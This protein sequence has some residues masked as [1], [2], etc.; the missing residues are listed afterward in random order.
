MSWLTQQYSTAPNP[1]IQ[2][3]R[4]HDVSQIG[5]TSRFICYKLND[6]VLV[7]GT[8]TILARRVNVVPA[9]P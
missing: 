8:A 6:C 4:G 2:P 1:D 3:L 7:G 5:D 9:Q